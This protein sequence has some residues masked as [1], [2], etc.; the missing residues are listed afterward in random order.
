MHNMGPW[1]RYKRVTSF[2]NKRSSTQFYHDW[3]PIKSISDILHKNFQEDHTNSRR[4]KGFPGVVDT[5]PKLGLTPPV[6]TCT[7]NYDQTVIFFAMVACT[8]SLWE[9]TITLPNSTIVDPFPQKGAVKKCRASAALHRDVTEPANISYL[10][11]SDVAFMC[12][13]RR[14][15][16]RIRICR[17]IKIA[18]YYGYCNPT[19]LLKIKQ[20]QTN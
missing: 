6:K 9:H 3:K 10:H 4:F 1:Q 19:Y 8:N 16:M 17:A 15:R 13:I 12:K 14:I 2:L 5:L 18:S 11:P 20:C 7:A